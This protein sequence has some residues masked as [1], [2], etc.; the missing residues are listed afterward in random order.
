MKCARHGR[1][2]DCYLY[3][4]NPSGHVDYWGDTA[5]GKCMLLHGALTMLTSQLGPAVG[6]SHVCASRSAGVLLLA[7]V[8]FVCGVCVSVC[9]CV[10]VCVCVVVVVLVMLVMLV[11]LVVLVVLMVLVVPVGGWRRLLM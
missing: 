1:Q 2:A 7:L 9:V 4:D 3:F 10:C 6:Q 8:W 5:P 11:V